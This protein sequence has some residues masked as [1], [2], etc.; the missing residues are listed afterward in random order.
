MCKLCPVDKRD[1]CEFGQWTKLLK[2][3]LR[4]LRRTKY[5]DTV[6]QL[7]SEVKARQELKAVTPVWNSEAKRYEPPKEGVVKHNSDDW[8]YK[9]FH[10]DWLPK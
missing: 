6:K 8:D 1:G 2:V 5:S 10:E 4:H 9:N 7:L 3:V